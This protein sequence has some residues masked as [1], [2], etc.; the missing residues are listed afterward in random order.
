MK[1]TIVFDDSYSLEKI[2]EGLAVREAVLTGA[3]DKCAYLREC[4]S[5]ENFEFPTCAPC[6]RI[7]RRSEN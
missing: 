4:S 1:N 5:N 7:M 3:C 2:K 6:M